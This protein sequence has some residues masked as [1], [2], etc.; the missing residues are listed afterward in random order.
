MLKEPNELV[1]ESVQKPEEPIELDYK[2]VFCVFA[3]ILLIAGTLYG[4]IALFV[5]GHWFAGIFFM[6]PAIFLLMF[7]VLL[8]LGIEDKKPKT[9]RVNRRMLEA[10]VFGEKLVAG[11]LSKLNDKW[12]VFND[13]VVNDAQIDH[14]L[15]GPKGIFCIETKTWASCAV[16]PDGKWWE[17]DRRD[18][19]WHPAH[20]N[21]AEQ[22]WFHIKA[23]KKL[24]GDS[25]IHSIIV[26][27][28]P[29]PR[30]SIGVKTAEPGH[31]RICRHTELLSVITENERTLSSEQIK[32]LVEN[33][34]EV[35]ISPAENASLQQLSL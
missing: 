2:D 7:G 31:A 33:L 5:Y 16:T 11:I 27:A 26:L 29:R 23:L 18:R 10:G 21:P 6:G 19:M 24:L 9:I 1:L 25:F 14:V 30:L 20:I 22:N 17:W 34:T 32:K 8:I 35:C 28:H 15:V 4:E 3:G 12:Y 13:I